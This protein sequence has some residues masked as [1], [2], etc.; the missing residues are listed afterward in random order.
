MATAAREITAKD[1]NPPTDAESLQAN[2][3]ERAAEII[4]RKDELIDAYGRTP[5]LIDNEEDAGKMTHMVKLLTAAE[6]TAE[7]KRKE[8]K[9]PFLDGGTMVDAFFRDLAKP[10]SDAK[11]AIMKRLTAYQVKKEAEERKRRDE[12][13]RRIAE[14]ARLA[15]EDADRKL[16]EAAQVE[17][18]A[19]QSIGITT[20]SHEQLTDAIEAEERAED[21]TVAASIAASEAAAPTADL[22]RTRSD[23]GSTSSLSKPWVLK[24]VDKETVDLEKLRAHFSLADIE[25]AARSFVKLGGRELTGA[26]IAQE[27][28]V[29]V[30]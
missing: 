12:E 1:N 7:K 10:I 2:L 30:R 28:K 26:V 9:Q 6:G 15:R 27:A 16:A 20:G 24:S 11:A 17:A 29:T 23:Y 14:Q 3:T 13:A 8:E 5:E 18:Q 4:K 25:K 22:T 19:G 21:L